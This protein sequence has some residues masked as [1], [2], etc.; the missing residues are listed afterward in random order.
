MVSTI[1]SSAHCK[2]EWAWC[3]Y[4]SSSQITWASRILPTGLVSPSP[5][6]TSVH[7][8][9]SRTRASES[10]KIP[11]WSLVASGLG[12]TGNLLSPSGPQ[13]CSE[14]R[15][16]VVPSFQ[17]NRCGG[18][19]KSFAV[20]TWPSTHMA[21]S[22]ADSVRR[23]VGAREQA[24]LFQ[25]TCVSW[26]APTASP[27]SWSSQTPCKAC[28]VS[29]SG[30]RLLCPPFVGCSGVRGQTDRSWLLCIGSSAM[31]P[32]APAP[33]KASGGILGAPCSS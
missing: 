18:P 16:H 9:S 26:I 20:F 4:M 33:L 12:L 29:S 14:A 28:S 8:P 32:D 19:L 10:S 1:P 6:P 21:T 15:V 13:T 30:G 25:T 24:L 17:T 7:V 27:R 3:G 11:L 22:L 23:L 2:S 31:A 5:A